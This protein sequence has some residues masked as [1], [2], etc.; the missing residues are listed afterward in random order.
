M[1]A[2]TLLL[3]AVRLGYV[4]E[5]DTTPT[6]DTMTEIGKMLSTLRARLLSTAS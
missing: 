2:E 5:A 3:I 6:L 4:T 1:E